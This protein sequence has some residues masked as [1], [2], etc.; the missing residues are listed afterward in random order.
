MVNPAYAQL[1][2]QLKLAESHM[3]S[4][5]SIANELGRDHMLGDECTLAHVT[6]GNIQ[7]MLARVTGR[8]AQ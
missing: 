8:S 7:C 4:V 1:I 6:L 5:V 3:E 2:V